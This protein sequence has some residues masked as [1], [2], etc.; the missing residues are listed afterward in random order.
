MI[1]WLSVRKDVCA[2]LTNNT[3]LALNIHDPLQAF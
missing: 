3:D 1:L 2:V